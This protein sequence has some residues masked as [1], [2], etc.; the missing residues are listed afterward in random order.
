[1][2]LSSPGSGIPSC[3]ITKVITLQPLP[4]V[5]FQLPGTQF[6]AGEVIELVIPGYTSTNTYQW[7]FDQTSFFASTGTTQITINT[8]GSKSVQLKATSP[9]GCVFESAVIQFNVSKPL[10]SGNLSPM[11]GINV[12]EGSNLPVIVFTGTSIDSPTGF[13]WMNGDQP[14]AG[15]P[16]SSSFTPT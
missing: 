14:V 9:Q 7:I 4:N 2:T 16:N 5:N 11:G 13:I 8:G 1:L 10:F 6:C 3:S 12:C 15:S